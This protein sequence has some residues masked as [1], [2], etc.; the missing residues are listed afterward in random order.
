MLPTRSE[1]PYSNVDDVPI[2]AAAAHWQGAPST[3]APGEDSDDGDCLGRL[4]L[5]AKD[6]IASI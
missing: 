3:E 5:N 1:S 6:H 2:T 4:L